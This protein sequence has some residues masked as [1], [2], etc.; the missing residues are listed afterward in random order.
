M[1]PIRCCQYAILDLAF[2]DDKALSLLMMEADDNGRPA[3]VLLPTTASV[4]GGLTCNSLSLN[5][6]RERFSIDELW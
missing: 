4:D 2:Y 1:C 5:S 3:L 6:S